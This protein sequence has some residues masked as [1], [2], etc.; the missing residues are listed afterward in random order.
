MYQAEYR[1][2]FARNNVR[3][4]GKKK[5]ST[6]CPASSW[7]LGWVF[8]AGAS[9]GEAR[10]AADLAE[11]N[12]DVITAAESIGSYKVIPKA[13]SSTSSTGPSSRRSWASAGEAAA[14]RVAL[15]TGGGWA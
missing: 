13:T 12:V 14:R 5:N 2:Y 1:A 3:H 10:I 7:C 15:V 8:R 11:T 9:E 4:D 6:R